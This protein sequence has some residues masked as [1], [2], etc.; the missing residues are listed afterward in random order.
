MK[1]LG[2]YEGGQRIKLFAQSVMLPVE[3]LLVLLRMNT[4]LFQLP[5]E[6]LFKVALVHYV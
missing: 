6:Q 3:M 5:L 4:N 2:V 1:S